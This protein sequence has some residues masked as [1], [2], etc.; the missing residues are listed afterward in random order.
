MGNEIQRKKSTRKTWD[1]VEENNTVRKGVRKRIDGN[2]AGP[3][4]NPRAV[5]GLQPMTG[6]IS[7]FYLFSISHWRSLLF[8]GL[9]SLFRNKLLTFYQILLCGASY[10][11]SYMPLI[12]AKGRG[13]AQ[14]RLTWAGSFTVARDGIMF[15][16]WK[17]QKTKV[18]AL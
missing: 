17:K 2:W 4:Q 8:W 13:F 18:S 3:S 5:V 7:H 10:E 16:R 12:A 15:A 11:T 1:T 14:G 9:F 6:V